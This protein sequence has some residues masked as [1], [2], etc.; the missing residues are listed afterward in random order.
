ERVSMILK[1]LLTKLIPYK[2][3]SSI[4]NNATITELCSW[5]A[6][7]IQSFITRVGVQQSSRDIF[8]EKQIDG[9]LLLA[10]TENELKDYFQMNNRKIRQ[11]LIENVIRM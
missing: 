7:D 6:K 10:C 11:I 8:V 2:Q 4:Q 5:T 9:Y 1:E 3:F